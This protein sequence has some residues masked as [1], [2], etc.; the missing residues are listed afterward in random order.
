MII[1]RLFVFHLLLIFS[2]VV[3]SEDLYIS[4]GFTPPVSDYYNEVLKEID[5]R[6]DDF[7]IQ[8][9]VLPAERSL[10]LVNN[11]INDG[12]CCRIPAVVTKNYT[13]LVPVQNSF[14]TTRFS[15]FSKDAD[16]KINSFDQLK[17][18][19]V[20]VPKGWKLVVNKVT[21]AEPRELFVVTA[22]EQLFRM[23]EEGRVDIG[24]VGYLSGLHVIKEHDIKGVS[25]VDPPMIEK[26][27]FLMLHRKH[28]SLIPMF[29]N[30]IKEMI[31]DGTIDKIYSKF[32]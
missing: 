20:V 16:L 29:D 3:N 30:V 19:S 1:I 7:T 25:A 28:E 8:F 15:F 10:A 5:R 11:G 21:E 4:T 13:N 23:L 14:F 24:M 31:N 27:L 9:E 2:H 17:P 22:P 18:Y 6:L 12:E 32:Q 26:D